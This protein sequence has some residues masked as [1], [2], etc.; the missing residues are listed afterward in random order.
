[1][2]GVAVNVTLLPWQTGLAEAALATL[3]AE[4]AF[5]V[6]VTEFD[7]AGLPVIQAAFDVSTQV[8]AS[9]LAGVYE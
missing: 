2:V 9:L 3:T 5:T 7:V 4:L 6:M 1:M 8:T